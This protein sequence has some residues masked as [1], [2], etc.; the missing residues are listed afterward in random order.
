MPSIH[1]NYEYDIFISY[2]HN[3]NRSG[4]V[5]DFVAALQVELAATIKE[6][7]SV[8]FDSN[9]HDGLLETH[10]VDKSLEKKLKCLILIPIISQTYC[11]PNCFAWQ[12]EL[13][14]FVEMAK[15]DELGMDITLKNG[16]VAKRVLPIR[17]HD[18][19]HADQQLF[20]SVIG[21][22][23]R[24]VDFIYKSSGVNR[25]MLPNEEEPKQNLNNTNYRNQINKVANSVKEIISALGKSDH[26]TRQSSLDELDNLPQNQSSVL[27][28]KWNSTLY[29]I[30][31]ISALLVLVT[32]FL[33]RWKGISI[34]QSQEK[35]QYDVAVMYLEN[36]T[37]NPKYGD[38]LASLVYINLS[39]HASLRVLPRQKLFDEMKEVTGLATVPDRDHASEISKKTGT[40]SILTGSVHQQG[41]K[42][43]VQLELTEVATGKIIKAEKLKGEMNQIFALADRVCEKMM[44][45]SLPQE[46]N[47]SLKTTGNYEAYQKFY[48]G[49]EDFYVVKLGSA[50]RKFKEAIALD[51][52][53][54]LGY[55]LLAQT[56][57]VFS[58]FDIRG[59]LDSTINLIEKGRKYSHKLSEKDRLI[60]ESYYQLFHGHLYE[61]NKIGQAI[62]KDNVDDRLSILPLLWTSIFN[63][64]DS[65]MEVIEKYASQNPADGLTQN[66]LSYNYAVAG[67]DRM[68]EKHIQ[69]YM[70]V[71]PNTPNA[72][73]S[74]FEIYMATGKPEKALK[75]IDEWEKLVGRNSYAKKSRYFLSLAKGVELRNYVELHKD[76]LPNAM[77]FQEMLPYSLFLQGKFTEASR[78]FDAVISRFEKMQKWEDV[79][80]L[81]LHKGILLMA[82]H[83]F[84]E[85]I[86]LFDETIALSR[87]KLMNTHNP[88]LFLCNY[89]AGMAEAQQGNLVLAENRLKL[90]RRLRDQ[91]MYDWRFEQYCEL[92][93]ASILLSNKNYDDAKLVLK[94]LPSSVQSFSVGSLSLSSTLAWQLKDYATAL[95]STTPFYK[96][97]FRSAIHQGGDPAHFTWER[98]FSGYKSARIFEDSGNINEAIKYYTSFLAQFKDADVG[99]IEKEDAINRLK[100]LSKNLN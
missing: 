31:G 38:Q 47:V 85:A 74:G 55:V 95:H 57:G 64:S 11:D 89:Y 58:L 35:F 32:F 41:E 65:T 5:T 4:W 88:S 39:D 7:V 71:E 27:K 49:L 61:A 17:I 10:D 56:Q 86:K 19:D 12:H 73:D 84:K 26:I 54:A 68:A 69:N 43:L 63:K 52:T 83:Q 78:E 60:I 51:S 97:Y 96:N 13:L 18:I 72:F 25:S 14:P 77:R 40:K 9:P 94:N 45:N 23:L 67:N 33:Y 6:S 21:G 87:E 50:S 3:D 15:H 93:K 66:V 28:P 37:E 100:E 59:S 53:F 46:F 98:T 75:Y 90:I 22:V 29:K 48:S 82:S 34:D 91:P 1:P 2:R 44:E 42:V 62:N 20:E 16:N 24:S 70:K 8:Y 76:S 36:F 80:F 99:I 81:R 79:L 92:L 30:I